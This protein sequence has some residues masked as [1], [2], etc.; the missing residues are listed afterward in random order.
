MTTTRSVSLAGLDTLNANFGANVISSRLEAGYR[1]PNG[2]L[3]FT[4]L[5]LGGFGVTPYAALEAQA[6]VLPAFS[7]WAGPGS[8]AQFALNYTSKTYTTTRTE[9]GAWFTYD[10]PLAGQA[11]KLYSRLAYAHDFNNEGIATAFFQQL[12]GGS[13]LINSAKPAAN[14]ALVT[15]GLEYKLI[16]GWSVLGKFDGE[17]SSTTEIFAGTGVIQKVW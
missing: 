16:D 14:D 15:A 11:L 1:L 5:P 10:L 12:P 17:F 9:L 3:P 8:S 4:A 6:M 13:F 7:E 2:L